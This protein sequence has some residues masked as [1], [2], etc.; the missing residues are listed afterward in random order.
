MVHYTTFTNLRVTGDFD[1]DNAFNASTLPVTATGRAFPST[2]A[3]RFSNILNMQ[4]DFGC[5]GD[6]IADDTA[7]FQA[8][9]AVSVAT[10]QRILVPAGTYQVVSVHVHAHWILD[11]G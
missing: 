2:L 5:L 11:A 9:A 1:A 10:G 6:G 3:D 7:K 8:A 4:D